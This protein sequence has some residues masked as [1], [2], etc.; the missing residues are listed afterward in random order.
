MPFWRRRGAPEAPSAAVLAPLPPVRD[1]PPAPADV[2]GVVQRLQA[3]GVDTAGLGLLGWAGE[4]PVC[5][6]DVDEG[7]SAVDRWR[8]L[9]GVHRSTGL[10]P[11]L[12]GPRDQ[13]GETSSVF[14]GDHEP[15][16]FLDGMRAQPHEVLTRLLR[17]TAGDAITQERPRLPSRLDELPEHFTVTD[18]PG[19]LAVVPAAAGWQ[20]PGLVSWWGAANVE[21]EPADHVA[22]LRSWEHRFGAELVALTYDTVELAVRRPPTAPDQVLALAR[23]MDAY[24][25]DAAGQDFGSLE[26]LCLEL[27][28]R[29]SWR[30][31]WD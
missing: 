28:P 10:W 9:R 27:V 5:G 25:P 21:V 31:W 6:W 19:V 15:A 7:S 17:R 23:E 8:A 13:L 26:G 3:A 2:D 16:A 1:V 30:F 22:V 11:V 29:R 24:C 18:E 20:L 4:L 14:G 12:L